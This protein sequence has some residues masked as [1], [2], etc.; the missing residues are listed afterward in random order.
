MV[1]ARINFRGTQ[2]GQMGPFPPGGK[3][4]DADFNYFFV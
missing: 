3:V 2:L 1:A 4:L